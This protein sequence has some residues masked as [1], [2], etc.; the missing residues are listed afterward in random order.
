MKKLGYSKKEILEAKK[1]K[2]EYAMNKQH[3]QEVSILKN[4]KKIN[5]SKKDKRS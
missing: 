3:D 4:L 1:K 2:T 5:E